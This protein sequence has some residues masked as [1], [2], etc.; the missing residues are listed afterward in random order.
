M[1]DSLCLPVGSEVPSWCVGWHV[2]CEVAVELPTLYF[3]SYSFGAMGTSVLGDTLINHLLYRWL[4]LLFVVGLWCCVVVI[5]GACEVFL[6]FR[7]LS[8]VSNLRTGVVVAAC[9]GG[10]EGLVVPILPFDV[11]W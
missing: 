10:S 7:C 5:V 8:D 1:C 2:G 11:C 6:V 4:L 3:L 9:Y